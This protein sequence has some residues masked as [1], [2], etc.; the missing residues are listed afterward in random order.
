MLLQPAENTTAF[1]KLGIFGFAGSGKTYTASSIA[2][3]LAKYIKQNRIAYFDTEGGTD[4]MIKR[5]KDEG[6]EVFQVKS[7]SFNDLV[8]TIKECESNNVPILVV[9]SVTHIW[10]DLCDSYDRKLKRDGKIQF[11]DNK[12]IKGEWNQKYADKFISFKVHIIVAGRAGDTYDYSLNE[13]GTKDLIKTGTKMKAETEFGF[14]PSL[15]IEM[16]RLT[17]TKDQVD[18]LAG[19]SDPESRQEKALIKPKIGSQWI[20]RAHIL[21]DRSDQIDGRSFDNPSFESILPHVAQLNIGGVHNPVNAERNSESA[22]SIKGKPDWAKDKERATILVEEME[23]L[24]EAILPGPGKEEKVG[25]SALKKRAF[26]TYSDTAIAA[27][28]PGVLQIGLDTI[29]AIV[30]GPDPKEAIKKIVVE[31]TTKA[32]PIDPARQ[33]LLN[34]LASEYAEYKDDHTKC[35]EKKCKVGALSKLPDVAKMSDKDVEALI[36]SI[37]DQRGELVKLL[38]GDVF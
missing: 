30:T 10:R 24:I 25:K 2:I 19:K 9:D 33:G 4:W 28:A 38:A 22:F 17:A 16:E 13:D 5:L 12:L 20:H 32:A 27:L 15:V 26:G 6:M 1:L 36:H 29:R 31:E 18:K 37:S 21:K 8:T 11:Q 7:R 34:V 23:G 35:V 3:G 14:E